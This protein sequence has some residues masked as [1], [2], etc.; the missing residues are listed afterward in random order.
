MRPISVVILDGDIAQA[1]MQLQRI[2][3]VEGFFCTQLFTRHQDFLYSKSHPDIVL[4]N[5]WTPDMDGL[6]VLPLILKKFP[7]T[8]VVINALHEDVSTIVSYISLG[9]VGYIDTLS[10]NDE[11]DLVLRTV[12]KEGAYISPRIA[13]KL[14]E[15]FQHSNASTCL[16]TQR[17]LQVAYL[18]K[19]GNSYKQVAIHCGI[20]VDTVRMHIR[21]I[22]KKLQVNSKV[23]L[24]NRMGKSPIMHM[25]TYVKKTA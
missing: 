18:I 25:E 24:A 17:E 12:Q 9:A 13:K 5:S 15:S 7:N 21:N 2:N 20:S 10:F 19:E 1:G 6:T 16:L 11:I 22:Y 23:Q 4:F 8:S 3:A 14:F